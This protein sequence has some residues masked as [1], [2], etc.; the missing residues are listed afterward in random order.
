LSLLNALKGATTLAD[1]AHLLG[2]KPGMLS[3]ELYIKPKATLYE[4]FTIP[5]RYGGSRE[6]WAPNKNLK[7]IQHRL[8]GL[9]ENCSKEIGS[10][11]GHVDKESRS[12]IAHGFKS[13]RSVF[14]SARPHI[15]RQRVFN[16]DLADFF[17][18][19]NFGRV[20]GFFISSKHFAL[21]PKVA[22]VLAQ[23]A[24]HDNKLPQ[25]SPCSPVISN[26]IGHTLDMLLVSLSKA[27]GCTYTRYADDL[28]FSSNKPRFSSRVAYQ[29]DPNLHH[30]EAGH[31]LKRALKRAGF[32][33]ND[34]KTR[35]Q[36][37]DSRQTVTGLTVNRKPNVPATY[38]NLVRAM[39]HSLFKTG[40]FEFVGK[41]Y[42]ENGGKTSTRT[43]G[44]NAQLVGMLAYIDF[45]D[46][47]NRTLHEE[48]GLDPIDTSGRIGLF[49]RVLY[50]DHFYAPSAPVII[51]EGKTDN[52]YI[53]CAIKSL[54]AKYPLLAKPGNPAKLNVR[55]F[56]YGERRTHHVTELK[57]GVNGLCKLIKH[58]H[59][60]VER[61]FK[62]PAPKH[63][64]IILIDNDSGANSV[65]GA[66]AGVT[67]K[68][69]PANTERYIHVTS[70]LYVVPT[71]RTQTSGQTK[72]EDF[73]KPDTL[74]AKLGSKSFDP[75]SDADSS[76]SYGKAAF[77]R[78]VIA[79]G[80][81][82]IDFS[83]FAGIL[84]RLTE[85]IG[86]YTSKLA[87][88]STA[89]ATVTENDHATVQTTL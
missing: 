43:P 19:I 30:W 76:A 21:N 37:R 69:K 46:Q 11:V 62:A 7:L 64:V 23:I 49:R 34:R 44:T 52:V 59:D 24:C 54:A 33:L 17:G 55:L 28:T 31:G 18:T 8:A 66:I 29:P 86:D 5:K 89:A 61:K 25:G 1:V 56:K 63:P 47:K 77:A 6:I 73:F 85:A 68:H 78:D 65:L 60:D 35:M 15:T 71:P 10:A 13:G 82:T 80:A 42:D 20:R 53:K 22:T 81:D 70:N 32:T 84:D 2:V 14:T 38:R 36:Y 50:F 51:C 88:R 75:S 72:I 3:N 12:A 74:A 40:R 41:V 67:G 87:A 57:G 83:N 9:L 79:R 26:L 4:K 45:V 16:V 39:A 27:T 48:S 58:Y